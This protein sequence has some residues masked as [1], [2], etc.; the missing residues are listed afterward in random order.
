[1]KKI[2][3]VSIP[4]WIE[5]IYLLQIF[6]IATVTR[7]VF[8]DDE[9]LTDEWHYTFGCAAFDLCVGSCIETLRLAITASN[10]FVENLSFLSLYQ[11]AVKLH[12]HGQ[13]LSRR[14]HCRRLMSQGLGE[15]CW[16]G[17]QRE[18]NVDERLIRARAPSVGDIQN[19]TF[20]TLVNMNFKFIFFILFEIFFTVNLNDLIV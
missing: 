12:G 3:R 5:T 10:V 8:R 2:D 14:K 7:P 15:K 9:Q 20:C 16:R 19:D 4:K 17:S 11:E 18:S 13:R 6:T 1:M